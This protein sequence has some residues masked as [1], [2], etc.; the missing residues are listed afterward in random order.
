LAAGCGS[1]E[2]ES[3]STEAAPATTEATGTVVVEIVFDGT[4]CSV[5]RDSVPAGDRAF[6]L[7]NT[8]D[9][10]MLRGDIY[11]GNL[12]QGSTYQDL[13]DRQAAYGGPPNTIPTPVWEGELGIE[14]EAP[15]F[16]APPDIE[17]AANQ[18]LIMALLTPGTDFVELYNN[19]N[20]TNDWQQWLCTP[21]LNV[22]P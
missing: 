7:T 2:G 5:G 16:A 8:S 21:A 15:S 1:S 6:L 17:P 9:L 18:T 4:E 12:P 19:A 10:E 11:I 3:A 13:I 22:T 14:Y 20:P